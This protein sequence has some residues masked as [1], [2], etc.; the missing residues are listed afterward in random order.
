MGLSED[1]A[2]GNIYIY[3]YIETRKHVSRELVATAASKS[4]LSS[5]HRRVGDCMDHREDHRECVGKGVNGCPEVRLLTIAC[6][7]DVLFSL[8]DAFTRAVN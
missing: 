5:K 4:H 7:V 3:I 8:V 6:E 1:G 2:A